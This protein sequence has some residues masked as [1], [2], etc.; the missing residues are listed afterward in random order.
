MSARSITRAREREAK[1]ME[2]RRSS[3]ARRAAAGTVA[4]VGAAAVLASPAQAATFEVNS[5]LDNGDGVCDATCTLRDAVETANLD[6]A[7]DDIVFNSAITG[8]IVLTGGQLP[9]DSAMSIQ[10]PGA[11]VLRVSGDANSNGLA[12]AGD[13]RVAR[14][15][16]DIAGA[17]YDAVSIS[18]LTLTEG[19]SGGFD[20]GAV[21]SYHS[22]VTFDR[23]AVVNST[24]GVSDEGGGL[25]HD[26]GDLAITDS[27]FRDNYSEEQGGGV[28]VD[29][30]ANLQAQTVVVRNTTMAQNIAEDGGGLY[31]QDDVDGALIA[32]STFFDNDVEDEGGGIG[33]DGTDVSV[34]VIQNSTVSGNR[35]DD[36]GGGIEIG[37][38]SDL[39]VRIEN[40]TI[41]ENV[42][43]ADTS[44]LGG[45]IYRYTNGG[46]L[47]VSST[48]VANN[49]DAGGPNDLAE[50][51][52]VPP[53]TIG[54][55]LV[56][57]PG[58]TVLTQ[59]PA[60]SNLIGVDP[61][62][63]PLAENGG[64]TRTHLPAD[65]SP[66]VDAGTA[67]GLQ[68]D[69]RGQPR[70][71]EQA[72]ANAPGSD[73]TDMGSVELADTAVIGA[74]A[75]AKK[76]QKVKGKKVK[77]VVKA[78]ADEVV[79]LLAAGKVKAGKK[80]YA[81]KSKA[82][83]DVPA[84]QDAKLTLKPKGKK[85]KKKIA[86]RAAAGKK[87]KATVTVTFTDQV[88]NTATDKVKVTLVGKKKKG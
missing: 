45:G 1:R 27:A 59:S 20:G 2:R 65:S 43:G 78:G 44:G 51:A 82:A 17:P 3:R 37:E 14:I 61:Q 41:A 47:N 66:V 29:G 77:V 58:A 87:S 48:I 11:D 34:P 46:P 13:S 9:I 53:L 19:Y 28:Y 6:P 88:G 83:N 56:E 21:Y 69:Q 80:S 85:A 62:L 79:D 57:N 35:A 16:T 54:F 10:G 38:Y 55:S 75:K 12:D 4:A 67:N 68:T 33:I 26:G 81:L 73:G 23:V 31:I 15:D 52:P 76:K 7:S 40:S 22:D 42:A 39:G 5:E 18:G 86:A 74:D 32:S 49:V 63:G 70:T 30:G 25:A 60:G 36:E 84:G 72:K 8:T 71:A 50:D 64:P 24:V